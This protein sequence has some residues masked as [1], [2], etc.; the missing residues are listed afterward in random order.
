MTEDVETAE[1]KELYGDLYTV[2]GIDHVQ[3]TQKI[4]H[5]ANKLHEA[6]EKIYDKSFARRGIVGV[7]M[8]VARKYDAI[9]TLG[10][11]NGYFNT[12]MIDALMDVAVYALKMIVTI[13]KLRPDVFQEWYEKVY[14][15]YVKV[16]VDE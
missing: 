1:Y 7:W 6:K 15:Q 3:D 14:Q 5:M 13:H 4:M 9:D 10:R 16:D 8:N 11:M 12:T 2:L